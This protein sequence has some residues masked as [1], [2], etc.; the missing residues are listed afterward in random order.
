MIRAFTE[1]DM[2]AV[3]RIWL[4][5]S[6]IAH[7]FIDS[8]YWTSKVEDMRTLYIPAAQTQV[9]DDGQIRG[10]FCLHE[11]SLAAL[12]VA[13]EDQGKGIGRQLMQRAIELAPNLDLTVY[14]KNRKTIRFYE[15]CGFSVQHEV[16]DAETGQPELFMVLKS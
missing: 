3:L 2:D 4:D 14:R 15:Q 13:P 10:F 12:F 8:S 6:I 5:A 1:T 7:D 9:Y 16:M 11:Q